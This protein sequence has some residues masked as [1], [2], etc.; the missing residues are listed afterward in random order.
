M[1]VFPLSPATVLALDCRS[2]SE[3]GVIEPA[4]WD[5]FASGYWHYFPSLTRIK[6]LWADEAFWACIA[7]SM[8][9]IY[10]QFRTLS[11]LDAGIIF[12]L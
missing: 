1:H 12:H 4:D 7:I 6:F 8:V 9:M 5:T 11:F 3:D 10:E 2:Y